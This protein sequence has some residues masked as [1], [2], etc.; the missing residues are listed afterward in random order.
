MNSGDG[1][2][3][4]RGNRRHA[5]GYNISWWILCLD[6]LCFVFQFNITDEFHTTEV[7]IGT[8]EAEARFTGGDYCGGYTPAR[9]SRDCNPETL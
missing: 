5:T 2:P 8:F 3:P 1:R 6:D 7:H 4:R 9:N